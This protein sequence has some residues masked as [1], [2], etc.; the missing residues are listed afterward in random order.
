M[1][2]TIVPKEEIDIK[3]IP[4]EAHEMIDHETHIFARNGETKVLITLKTDMKTS[5]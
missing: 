5:G 2:S 1:W 4:N 3:T